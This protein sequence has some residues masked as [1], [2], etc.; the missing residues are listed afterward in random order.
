MWLIA[1]N[2]TS[3]QGRGATMGTKVAGYCSSKGIDYEIITGVSAQSL[4]IALKEKISRNRVL[5]DGIIAVG[6]DGLA[7]LILQSAIPANIP[8]AFIPNG[9]GND[10]C[11]SIGLHSIE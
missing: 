8:I 3:G 6:G 4:S 10:T 5:I 2:P 7:H 11:K 1:I 9:S